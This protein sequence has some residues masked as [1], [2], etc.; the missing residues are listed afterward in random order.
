MDNAL[1]NRVD[2]KRLLNPEKAIWPYR[3]RKDKASLAPFSLELHL[4]SFCNYNCYHCSYQNRRSSRLV[5]NES[6][7]KA[8]VDDIIGLEIN[9]VYWS[10]GGEP[11]TIKDFPAYIEE[12]SN[13]KT[14]Q[15]LITNGLLI[16]DQWISLLK[17]FNYVAISFQASRNETYERI[18]GFDFREKLYSNIKRL[19]DMLE[20]T[21]LGARCVINKHNYT[22]VDMIYNDAKQLGID[23]LIFIPAVDYEKRGDVEL[24]TEERQLLKDYLKTSPLQ[25]IRSKAQAVMMKSKGVTTEDIGDILSRSR[26]TINRWIRDWKRQ[27]MGSLFTGHQN[28]QNASKLT[29]DQKKEIAFIL[30]SPPSE[31]GLSKAFWDV[32]TL[33]CYVQAHFGVVY[34]SVQSYHFLLKFSQ[35]SFKYPDTFDIHR[36]EGA[37]LE[38][39]NEIRKEI[40]PF[41]E[42]REWDVFVADEVRIELETHSRRAW[43]QRGERTI[44]KV[45]RNRKSQNYR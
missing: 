19:R 6:S 43:L 9:G 16:H 3:E 28:N 35:L 26:Y 20:K 42:D 37:I 45:N 14:E 39:M 11:T 13:S 30:K 21:I 23:Y 29:I 40:K 22:E 18:T 33:K 8:L 25:L 10:G 1:K 41:M 7:I 44:L 5:V 31:Y 34:E 24:N 2:L 15:A 38:R 17:K 32:P 4:T 36:D 27:N 12:I